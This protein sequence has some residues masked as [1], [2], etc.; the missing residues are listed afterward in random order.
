MRRHRLAIPIAIPLALL[1]LAACVALNRPPIATFTRS[2]AVGDAPLAVFFDAS[3]SVDPDGAV[4][5]YAW[6]FGD[7]TIGDG[8]RTAHM[9]AIAGTYEVTLAVADDRGAEGSAVRAVSVSDPAN[10]PTV[11]PEVGQLAPDFT[12]ENLEGSE[13]SLSDYRGYVVLLDF[14]RSTC[15]SCRVTM[16][17]LETLRASYAAEGL[18]V[19]AVNLD[20]TEA[21]AIDFLT[22]NGFDAFIALHGSLTEAEAVRATYGVEG[23]P[24]TF[25]IDRQ[26]IV[27][28]ADHP[29]RL[30]DRH[31]EPWL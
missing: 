5:S 29:I 26:G 7:G 15:T 31:I 14:W 17:H 20:V 12:L 10:P 28:H 3:E 4:L 23:I 25:V 27:R 1:S 2:P 30:R 21:E 13:V 19:I 24:H 11:G 8:P 6:A 16:P 18:V 22:E 9:Y